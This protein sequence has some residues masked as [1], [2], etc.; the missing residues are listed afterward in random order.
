PAL[1]ITKV[2][3]ERLCVG[4]GTTVSP[5]SHC[6]SQPGTDYALATT[7]FQAKNLNP[8]VRY[9][10]AFT[11]GDRIGGLQ[12]NANG[13]WN[14]QTTVYLKDGNHAPKV[15]L[16]IILEVP[17]LQATG[18]GGTQPLTDWTFDISSSDPNADKLRYRLANQSEL[19]CTSGSC[20]YTNP[21]G[22]S[23]NPNTGLLT[24]TGSGNLT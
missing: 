8:D 22:L 13:G 1:T 3:E 6:G 9:T 5:T 20:G 23:I 12:N 17:M 19:G 11:S 14:I 4:P 7:L 24:W 15:D 21:P 2:S 18:G 16:P 10:I